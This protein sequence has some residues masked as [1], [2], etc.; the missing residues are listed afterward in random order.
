ME[1]S[2]NN[3]NDEFELVG[4]EDDENFKTKFNL[5]LNLINQRENKKE[6]ENDFDMILTKGESQFLEEIV[7]VEKK[8]FSLI[9]VEAFYKAIKKLIDEHEGGERY[10]KGFRKITL[11]DK[12]AGY[13][14]SQ[15]TNLLQIIERKDGRTE[16]YEKIN[17]NIMDKLGDKTL[18]KDIETLVNTE[19]YLD[20][21]INAIKNN[22]KGALLIPRGNDYVRL[23]KKQLDSIE[24]ALDK[25]FSEKI[26]KSQIMEEK[27]LDQIL[28]NYRSILSKEIINY[29][30]ETGISGLDPLEEL[31]EKKIKPN[32]KVMLK[33]K[34]QAKAQFR[35]QDQ[36]GNLIKD[37]DKKIEK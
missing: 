9:P 10:R 14:D 28:D 31:F 35:S 1:S 32:A 3:D 16:Q 34:N 29:T 15:I 30:I 36:C 25:I 2:K 33:N 26:K 27:H 17:P 24:Y 5:L 12:K 18:A 6:E 4:G 37:F 13:Y 21:H 19:P 20:I 8:D 22:I 7:G 11:D 23:D